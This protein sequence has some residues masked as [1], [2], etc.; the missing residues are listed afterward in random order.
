MDRIATPLVIAG[1]YALGSVS[2]AWI[3]V[4]LVGRR[5]LRAIGSGNLGATNAGRILGRRWAVIIYALDLLKGL[6]PVVL[7][8]GIAGPFIGDSIPM[9]I[10]AGLAAILG[11][12]FPL[13]FR[14]RG[15]KGVATSSGVVLGL[16]P[17]A[18]LVAFAVWL[19]A[20]AAGRMVSLASMA[21]ALALPVATVIL[22]GGTG[23]RTSRLVFFGALAALV[24]AKHRANIVRILAGKEPRVGR[25]RDAS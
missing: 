21:A 1:S 7:A 2:F 24:I 17:A 3:L 18:A 4:R 5:D 10:P 15:G 23:P 22:P 12:V 8:P 14:F 6:L 16:A 11:H 9:G 19:V 13:W 25:R 20:L